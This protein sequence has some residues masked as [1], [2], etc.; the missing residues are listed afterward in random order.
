MRSLP[1]D[2]SGPWQIAAI[3]KF[4]PGMRFD[5]APLPVPDDH[6]GPVYTSG[7]YKNIAIFGNTKHPKESWEFVKFLITAEHDLLMLE[8]CNQIPVRGDLLTDSLFAGYFRRNP[9]MVRFAEQAVF[10]R[11]M[12]AVPDLKEIFD[13]ISQQYE[14][15]A[16]YGEKSPREAV[17]DAAQHARLIIEWNR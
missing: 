14:I 3:A 17:R 1:L 13:T 6:T 8:I 10:T 7:D 2:F 12:D 15:C 9:L 16:V 11:G 4:A 5:V